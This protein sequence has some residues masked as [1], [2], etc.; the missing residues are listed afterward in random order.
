MFRSLINYIFPPKCF[1]CNNF[2]NDRDG[3][4]A[5]CWKKCK[6]ISKPFCLVCCKKF[7]VSF[8]GGVDVC[9]VCLFSR[10]KI[11]SVR[12]LL[13]FSPEIKGLVHNFKYNDKTVLGKFFARLIFNNFAEEFKDVDF[14]VP[15]PMHKIKR[16]WRGYN[17]PQVLAYALGKFI[18]KP[19]I[20]DLLIKKSLTK[21]Q[22][23]LNKKERAKN[24]QG[25]LEVNEKFDLNSKVV[26][27]VDDVVTTGATSNEC[28]KLL[29]NR[30]A[31]A[32]KLV[33]IA[34]R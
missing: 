10:S 28:A 20:P 17:P 18:N 8:A 2:T 16:L 14:I 32:V 29:K 15:V 9:D 33:A 31:A 24:L 26:L 1:A 6:F 19:V 13:E 25:S 5:S 7:E 12:A 11:D 4:C 21:T 34:K 27:L 22:V 3:I 23:G 30:K